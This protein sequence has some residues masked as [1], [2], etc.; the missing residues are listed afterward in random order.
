MVQATVTIKLFLQW[1]SF[2][3]LRTNIKAKAAYEAKQARVAFEAERRARTGEGEWM[4]ADVARRI[5][6]EDGDRSSG[7]KRKRKKDK[8][9]KSE[10]KKSKS[11]KDKK[12][13]K[14]KHVCSVIA[15]FLT[16]LK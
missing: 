15:G 5:T 13:H 8:K 16:W 12:K 14:K 11:S 4:V 1:C 10:K 3:E 6:S 7:D 9:H 2:F